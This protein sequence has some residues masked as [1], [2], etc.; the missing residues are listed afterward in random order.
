MAMHHNK[1]SITYLLHPL[2]VLTYLD[3][4]KVSQSAGTSSPLETASANSLTNSSLHQQLHYPSFDSRWTSLAAFHLAKCFADLHTHWEVGDGLAFRGIS[5]HILLG[6]SKCTCSCIQ[7]SP[8]T[9]WLQFIHL[10]IQKTPSLGVSVHDIGS[11][12]LL[13]LNCLASLLMDIV[14]FVMCNNFC[15]LLISFMVIQLWL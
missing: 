4:F 1:P 12:C 15:P 8:M 7:F 10:V 6:I 3:Q 13:G 14:N 2:H 5:W 9:F 11:L